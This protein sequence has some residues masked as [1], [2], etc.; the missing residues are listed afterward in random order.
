MRDLI[1]ITNPEYGL[2]EFESVLKQNISN[3]ATINK[4][5]GQVSIEFKKNNELFGEIM[6]IEENPE[7]EQF[8]E[9][10]ELAAIKEVVA[11]PRFYFIHFKDIE[12][13]K[14]ILKYLANRSDVLVDNDHG[15]IPIGKDFVKM[16]EDKIGWDWVKE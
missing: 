16:C 9:P 5:S 14:L 12:H 3:I 8:S 4:N 10:E 7:V 11:Y 1:L 2:D 6:Q 15:L 13:L